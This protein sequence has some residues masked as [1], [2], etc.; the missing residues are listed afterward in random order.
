[1]AGLGWWCIAPA[2]APTGSAPAWT[3]VRSRNMRIVLAVAALLIAGSAHANTDC[4]F[5]DP[6]PL[7]LALPELPENG[8]P[9]A[10]RQAAAGVKSFVSPTAMALPTAQFRGITSAMPVSAIIDRLGPAVRDVGSGLY[11]LEWDVTDG[12]K[13]F[14]STAG[15]CERP[16]AAGFR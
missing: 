5:D 14:V 16:F 4:I 12:R 1:M 10:R 8:A 9:I 3:S 7:A 11:V 6:P 15:L 2:L 13:F